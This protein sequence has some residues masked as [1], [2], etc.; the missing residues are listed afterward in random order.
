[1]NATDVYTRLNEGFQ[2]LCPSGITV[3]MRRISLA[4]Y[5]RSGRVPSHLQALITTVQ[6]GGLGA[7]AEETEGLTTLFEWTLCE[8][9]IDPRVSLMPTKHNKSIP[10]DYLPEADKA[11]IF[12]VAISDMAEAVEALRPLSSPEAETPC[13]SSTPSASATDTAPAN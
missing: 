2:H 10:L 9:L 4:N 6:S 1:M 5:V 7:A 13:S 11:D 12:N 8:S 3:T